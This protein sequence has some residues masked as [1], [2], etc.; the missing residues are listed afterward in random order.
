MTERKWDGREGTHEHAPEHEQ[1]FYSVA[2]PE[3]LPLI[4]SIREDGLS[5]V[6]H[7]K[8]ASLK[9]EQP[10]HA[11]PTA[12]LFGNK[13]SAYK[14]GVGCKGGRGATRMYSSFDWFGTHWQYLFLPCHGHASAK[15]GGCRF[16][17]EKVNWIRTNEMVARRCSNWAMLNQGGSKPLHSFDLHNFSEGSSQKSESDSSSVA[18]PPHLSPLPCFLFTV[19]NPAKQL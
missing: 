11:V 12:T 14:P 17:W 4:D 19:S 8:T 2:W 9:G 5:M 18:P 6:D 7:S 1:F 13:P 16:L 15:K 3:S 10:S